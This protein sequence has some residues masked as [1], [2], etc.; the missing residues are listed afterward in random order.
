[1]EHYDEEIHEEDKKTKQTR[2]VRLVEDKEICGRKRTEA[3][4]GQKRSSC[5][6]TLWRKGG[7]RMGDQEGESKEAY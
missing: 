2:K 6:T 7:M 4:E 5:R 1:M 3:P